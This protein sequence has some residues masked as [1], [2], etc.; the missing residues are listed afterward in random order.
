MK[1]NLHDN[2]KSYE[3]GKLSQET[4]ANNPLQQFRNWFYECQEYGGVDEVNA[5]TL[6][7]IDAQGFPKGRVVLL[8]KYDEY[9]FYFY[10]NYNSEKGKA[11]E[12][13]KKVSLSFFWPNL[14]RQVI[15]KG[16]ASKIS[17]LASENYFHSRPKGSQIGALVS[18]QS[19]VIKDRSVLVNQLKELEATYKNKDVPM[20]VSW[21]GYIVTPISFEFWQGRPNRLHDR[22]RYTQI[23]NDWI[24]E[25]LA[26]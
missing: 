1:D 24:I 19:S 15:I 17:N 7:T 13:N 3:K 2:R 8:K 25:R 26:P 20:P 18:N 6:T 10:T 11:I 4:A 5:M 14:E 21:G 12:L 9:G 22:I 16:T 23:E